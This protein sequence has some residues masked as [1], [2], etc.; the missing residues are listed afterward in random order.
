MSTAIFTLTC[1]EFPAIGNGVTAV[2]ALLLANAIIGDEC[3][4]GARLKSV[5]NVMIDEYP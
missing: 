4:E 2:N 3:A 5:R 1:V